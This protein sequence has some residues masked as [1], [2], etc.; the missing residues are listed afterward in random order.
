MKQNKIRLAIITDK[1]FPSQEASVIRIHAL[2]DAWISSGYFDITIFASGFQK[3][4]KQVKQIRPFFPIP[5]NKSNILIRLWFEFLL[6]LEYFFHLLFYRTDFIF[7]SSPP[8]VVAILS[9]FAARIRKIPY[10]FDVRDLYPA[11]YYSAGILNKNSFIIGALK[12]I[13]KS[14]YQNSYLITTV[15]KGLLKNIQKKCDNNTRVLL[16][17]NGYCSN[18]IDNLGFNQKNEKFTIVFHGNIGQFQDVDL[19]LRLALKCLDASLD[20]EFVIIGEGS[21][22]YIVK[23]NMIPNLSYLGSLD[24]EKV[25][26][27][28]SKAHIGISFRKDNYISQQSFPVKLYEYIGLKLPMIVTPKCEAGELIEHYQIGYQFDPSSLELIFSKVV[29]L[30]EDQLLMTNLKE[31][32]SKISQKFSREK[33]AEKFVKELEEIIQPGYYKK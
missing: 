4:T 6:G 8:F 31:N 11:V 17:R 5:T 27:I 32:I 19:I 13:E 7:I 1:I 3:D 28:I 21:K 24:V 26:E 18:F 29:E 10:I 2:K 25:Y 33:F 15:T 12:R 9:A 20:V 14:I 23:N 30:S 22:D 16:L